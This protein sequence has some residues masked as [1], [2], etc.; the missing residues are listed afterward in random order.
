VPSGSKPAAHTPVKRTGIMFSK[1]QI[2]TAVAVLFHAIGFAGILFF[3]NDIII[4]STPFNLLLMFG[5]LIWTQK[6]KNSSFW[7]FVLAIF[8]TGIAVEVTGVN[9]GLLFGHYNYGSVLGFKM[10]NVPLIIGVNWFIIIYCCGISIQTLLTK[11]IDKVAATTATPPMALKALSVIIDGAT[12]AVFF[13][14]LLEP[15]AVQLGY[16]KWEGEIP[17]YNYLCWFAISLI[18]LILFNVCKFNKQNKF[19][20]HLLLI[21]VM[22]FLLLRTFLSQ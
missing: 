2:A 9:T 10:F 3:K 17:L 20:V 19:A 15:V 14:W 5:L 21:Q 8:I 11:A 13:D 4:R 12:L 16:W 22:F 1:N 7:L 6:E 18:M